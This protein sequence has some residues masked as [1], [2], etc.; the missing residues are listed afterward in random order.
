VVHQ[1]ASGETLDSVAALYGVSLASLQN[2]NP[3]VDWSEGTSVVVPRPDHPWPSHTVRRGETLWRI[4]KAYGIGVEELRQANGMN[5]ST[6]LPGNVLVL[7]RAVKPEWSLPEI[8][9]T[10]PAS[11]PASESYGSAAPNIPPPPEPMLQGQWVEVRL[12]DNRRAWAPVG[13]LVVGSWQPQAPDRVI[14]V[15][16]SFVGVPYKWGGVDPNGWDCSGFVQEVFRLGG[17]QVPRLADAQY[18][19]CAKVEVEALQPGDLVFFNTDGSGVSHVGIYTGNDHFLHA[20]SSRGVV[21]DSLKDSYFAERYYGGGRLLEWTAAAPPDAPPDAPSAGPSG[22]APDQ[23][24]EQSSQAD[25]DAA[26]D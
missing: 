15:G 19:A 10:V 9:A 25:T 4:G 1:L 20:S 8:S 23:A 2:A 26:E 12:P 5:D 24:P 17:H 22:S 18:Q 7:P 11:L 16:R 3:E 21:E 13:S 14:A 6:L